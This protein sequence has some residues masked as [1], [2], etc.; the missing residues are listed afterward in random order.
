MEQTWGTD[1]LD[2]RQTYSWGQGAVFGASKTFLSPNSSN[3]TVKFDV[4]CRVHIVF[5]VELFM[6][7]R[8]QAPSL[9][10]CPPSRTVLGHRSKTVSSYRQGHWAGTNISQFCAVRPVLSCM[11]RTTA[12]GTTSCAPRLPSTCVR[13]RPSREGPAWS[14]PPHPSLS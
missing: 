9:A 3:T 1:F 11:S 6:F 7:R 8:C 5:D 10:G 2:W 4:Q 13:P 12:S 14:C